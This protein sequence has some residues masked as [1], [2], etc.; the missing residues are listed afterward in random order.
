MT[1]NRCANNLDV[2]EDALREMAAM[3]RVDSIFHTASIAVGTSFMPLDYG[4][5]V[6]TEDVASSNYPV[7]NGPATL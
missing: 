2:V 7:F 6:F 4:V 5:P 3:S 1:E